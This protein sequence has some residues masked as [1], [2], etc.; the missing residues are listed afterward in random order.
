MRLEAP[1]LGQDL[2]RAQLLVH[3]LERLDC[4]LLHLRRHIVSRELR[5]CE[6]RRQARGGAAA[7]LE[8]GEDALQVLIGCLGRAAGEPVGGERA[9][10]ASVG[11]DHGASRVRLG[12]EV[13]ERLLQHVGEARA[14]ALPTMGSQASA[15]RPVG[16]VPGARRDRDEREDDEHGGRSRTPARSA[17]ARRCRRFVGAR[18]RP[19]R[20][21]IAGAGPRRRRASGRRARAGRSRGTNASE[22]DPRAAAAPARE[23]LRDRVPADRGGCTPTA[24]PRTPSQ[25]V[26]A[27][28]RRRGSASAGRR[29]PQRP[30]GTEPVEAIATATSSSTSAARPSSGAPSRASHLAT[31]HRL[32]RR[33]PLAECWPRPS[34]MGVVNVT[35]DSFSD[36]GDNLDPATAV[37][38]AR[39][40][41][42]EGAAARRHRRRVDPPRRRGRHR[43]RGAAPR[44]AGARG[45]AAPPVS[46]DTSK[47]EV[48]GRALELGASLVNDVTALRGDPELAGVSPTRART[49]ASCTCRESL[50]RCR[51]S[52]GTTTSSPRWPRSSRSGW[53]PPSRPGFPRSTSASTRASASARRP[54]RTSSSSAASTGSAGSA[55]PCSS[56][57]PG[58]AR[59]RGSLGDPT[60]RVGTASRPR[61]ARPWRHSTAARRLFRAHD[62]APHV[63]ALAAAAAVERGRVAMTIELARDRPARLPR[64]PRGGAARRAAVP[65]RRR[66]RPRATSRPPRSDRIEDAVDYRRRRRAR[67]ADLRRARLPPARGLRGGARRR[68]ARRVSRSAPCASG[69]ASPTSCSTRRSSY[70]A[71]D[72]SSAARP[73]SGRGSADAEAVRRLAAPPLPKRDREVREPARALVRERQPLASFPRVVA[74]ASRSLPTMRSIDAQRPLLPEARGRGSCRPSAWPSRRPFFGSQT[75]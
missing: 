35:P 7:D 52:R 22:R 46:I 43:G 47:A 5:P 40:L 37:A 64:R 69:C 58:R 20:A 28:E 34:V 50:A 71:V 63:E 44:R 25:Q 49:S 62:V 33:L 67:R 14:A 2:G 13:V 56:A 16:E 6:E 59:W 38:T 18:F 12:P 1:L 51:S 66:A 54:T 24:R 48:A 19:I 74:R 45:L 32:V 65:R 29:V 60:A 39:R 11:G 41:L 23:R 36:G 17:R 55:G 27:D 70:A 10:H 21:A 4:L 75:R 8:V 9:L 68:A 53:R 3:R 26:E 72:A 31:L 42:A 57:S 61:S 30:T 15:A 73:A